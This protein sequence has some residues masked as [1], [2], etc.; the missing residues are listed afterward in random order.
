MAHYAANEKT[1]RQER[2]EEMALGVLHHFTD[3]GGWPRVS[4][5]TAGGKEQPP[6]W[7]ADSNANEGI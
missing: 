6:N 3:S 1:I 4:C 7:P 2:E 5:S